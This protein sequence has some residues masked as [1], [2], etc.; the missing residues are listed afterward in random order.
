MGSRVEKKIQ[1]RV[2]NAKD[3]RKKSYRN[4]LL[5]TLPNIYT[6]TSKELK[7]SY[8]IAG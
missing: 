5:E 4:L 3:L 1:G 6:N 2:N 8:L 7:W